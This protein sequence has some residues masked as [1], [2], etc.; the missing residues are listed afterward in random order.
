MREILAGKRSL[1]CSLLSRFSGLKLSLKEH[2]SEILI[3]PMAHVHAGM[4]GQNANTKGR[5]G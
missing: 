5:T 2:S 4:P 1:K 3:L